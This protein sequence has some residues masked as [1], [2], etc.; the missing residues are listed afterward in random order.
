MIV[1][2]SLLAVITFAAA[3]ATAYATGTGNQDMSLYVGVY[4]V[5]NCAYSENFVSYPK[6]YNCRFTEISVTAQPNNVFEISYTD[7]LGQKVDDIGMSNFTNKDQNTTTQ[8]LFTYSST[9]VSWT[10]TKQMTNTTTYTD[11]RTFTLNSAAGTI[12]YDHAITSSAD[13]SYKNAD[14]NY[15]LVRKSN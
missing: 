1:L 5:K 8:G 13:E 7:E 15:T 10:L 6:D 2:K 11:T 9:D 12:T 3:G 4:S 14:W